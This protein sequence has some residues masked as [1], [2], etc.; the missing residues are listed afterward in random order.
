MGVGIYL[1][2]PFIIYVLE[3]EIWIKNNTRFKN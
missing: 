2:H 3:Y 1:S